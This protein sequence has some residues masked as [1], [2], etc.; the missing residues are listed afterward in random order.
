M[1]KLV[2]ILS[3]FLVSLSACANEKPIL[4]EQLPHAAQAF[5]N[6]HFPS[7]PIA[8]IE[9]EREGLRDDYKVYFK[10]GAELEFGEQGSLQ[11][12]DCQR[13]E[14]PASIIPDP[15]ENYV[16][17]YFPGAFI[18]SYSIDYRHL[19]VELNNDFELVFDHS[20]N[21]IRTDD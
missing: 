2:I 20:Y 7:L 5:I 14:V 4:F 8:Y 3:V 13:S 12:V 11:T 15:I 9:H 18:V 10:N 6:T 17:Q 21:I 1:R 19:D 16:S